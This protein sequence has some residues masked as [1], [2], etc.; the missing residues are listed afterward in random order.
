MQFL[1]LLIKNDAAL[2][3][4]FEAAAK[5]SHRSRPRVRLSQCFQ[6]INKTFGIWH[7]V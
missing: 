1:V 3:F 7:G 5:M 6:W 4:R 2:P